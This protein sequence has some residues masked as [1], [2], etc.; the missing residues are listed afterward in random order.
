[1]ARIRAIS[2]DLDDTLWPIRPTIARAEAALLDWL[3]Q[4]APA[5]AAA[6]ADGQALRALGRQV[7]ALRPG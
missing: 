6:L 7:L 3:G 4:H 1:M 5:T 2:I